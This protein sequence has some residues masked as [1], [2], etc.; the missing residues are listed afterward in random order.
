MSDTTA[1]VL[2]GLTLPSVIDLAAGN[3][4][5]DLGVQV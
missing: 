2:L 3:T 1:P 5:F 4:S